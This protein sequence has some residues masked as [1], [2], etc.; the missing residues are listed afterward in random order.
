MKRAFHIIGKIAKVTAIVLTAI[1]TTVSF[2]LS[3]MAFADQAIEVS[4]RTVPSYDKKDLKEIL[5]KA[6]WSDEDYRLLYE[7]TGLGR[8][9][10]DTLK[11]RPDR[12]LKFQEA[13]FYEGEIQ[14]LEAAATTPHEYFSDFAAPIAPLQDGDVIVTSTCHTYGW[15]NGHAALVVDGESHLILQSIGP[16]YNSSVDNT[17]WF[18]TSTNFLILRMKDVSKE[19]RAAIA[20]HAEEHYKNI[21]YSVLTG[22]FSSKDQGETP[23][24][25]H[26]SHLVWQCYYSMGY[27]IDSD[28]G[29]VCTANDIANSPLFEVVQVYGFD[30]DKLWE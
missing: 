30:V 2:A 17:Y 24:T 29:K 27:D 7:Q 1:L 28:G 15:R 3:F 18:S 14:H 10:L 9:S 12:I 21:P 16:G 11:E 5:E 19:D 4:A 8:M 22:I 23:A 13:L 25:T 26:C 20:R 6:E